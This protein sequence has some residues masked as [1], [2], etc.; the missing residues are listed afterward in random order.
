MLA[1]VKSAAP[2]PFRSQLIEVECDL[3]NSLPGFSVVGLPD[4][5]IEE[6]R[7]RVRGAIKN[8]GLKVPPKRIILNLAPADLPK[9]GSAYDLA[10][11]VA[12]LAASGQIP[13]PD[14][15]TLFAGEL[16]LDGRLRPIPVAVACMELARSR[17][18]RKV[19]LPADNSY[20]AAA[21]GGADVYPVK[22]LEELVRHL[23]DE[24]TLSPAKQPSYRTDQIK[25]EVDLADIV[26][27][28][29]AKRA[30][31][32]AA[33]GMHNLIL[34]GP[35]GAGKTLLCRALAGLLP[36]PTQEEQIEITKLH[37]LGGGHSGSLITSR[38]FRSPHHSAS[39][40]SLIG[41]TKRPGE[42]SL[43]HHGILFMDE[44][45]EFNRAALEAMRQPL[46][47]GYITIAR[48]NA[49]LRLPAKFLL[50]ATSNPCPCGYYDDQD[51]ACECT[52]AAF[53]R[54][55]Q[56]LSG[57]L[58]DR[59][60][61]FIKVERIKTQEMVSRDKR[62]DTK[63]VALRV[64]RA[65]VAQL[66]RFKGSKTN[67]EMT[68]KEID[69]YCRLTDEGSALAVQ[70]MQRLGLSGRGYH[71]ALRIARTIADLEGS[72]QIETHHL[73]EALAYRATV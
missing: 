45:A 34:T 12:I 15:N 67:S 70:A 23:K 54:Y 62:E 58:I 37:S 73:A 47:D 61:M 44:L 4:K 33:A 68:S 51:R 46:E 39:A 8:S 22:S 50:A 30:L 41:S 42:I 52:G 40:S 32:I 38:P 69:Q 65:R 28:N 18:I 72:N 3:S 5:S 7:E 21:A 48:A 31:E 57:P 2:S 9:D 6:S 20:E 19:Y 13:M 10:M 55:R 26:G 11:A 60:D 59:I 63:T 49:T 43:A 27:Q 29:Q 64:K 16:S 36:P 53:A 24:L 35:P 56:K 66:A 14:K 17:N 1:S 71:R 25:A